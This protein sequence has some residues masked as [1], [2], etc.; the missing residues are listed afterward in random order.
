MFGSVQKYACMSKYVDFV[1]GH[2]GLDWIFLESQSFVCV[3]VIM[4]NIF[5]QF[6]NSY[7]HVCLSIFQPHY[8]LCGNR[9]TQGW[10]PSLGADRWEG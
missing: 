4:E 2:F 6:Q 5:L 1:V 7:R 10:L 9:L 3:C 8:I